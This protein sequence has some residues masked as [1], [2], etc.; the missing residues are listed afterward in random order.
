MPIRNAKRRA[1]GGCEG[2]QN[3]APQQSEEGTSRQGHDGGAWKRQSGNGDVDREVNQ[4][5]LE[6]ILVAVSGDGILAGTKPVE[7]DVATEIESEKD[8][9]EYRDNY[10]QQ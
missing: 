8:A 3:G 2:D 10:D 1:D 9:D 6:H 5:R 4:R 7:T